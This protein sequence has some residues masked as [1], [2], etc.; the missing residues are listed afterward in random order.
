MVVSD[1]HDVPAPT[2]LIPKVL[3][4]QLVE[5]PSAELSPT[6][7]KRKRKTSDAAIIRLIAS[8]VEGYQWRLD[9]QVRDTCQK[10]LEA[11]EEQ[12]PAVHKRLK[13]FLRHSMPRPT[14]L[15]RAP[16]DIVSLEPTKLLLDQVVLSDEVEAEIR[17]LIT[18][19]QR[20]E[21][22]AEFALQPRH[23]VLLHGAPGNGK[24]ML[25]EALAGELGL[26]F[27]R[28]KYS[29]VVASHLGE[30]G[31]NIERLI[32]YASS[33]PCVLF[34]DEFDGLAIQRNQA[35]DVTEMRRVTN[36]MLISLDRLPAHC[37]FVAATNSP[38]L[39][40]PAILRRFDLPVEVPPPDE[41]LRRRAAELEL[42]PNLT[43]GMD[44]SH[45]AKDV[46]ALDL[47]NLY[48]VV[49]LCRRIRRDLVLNEGQGIKSLITGAVR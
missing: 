1:H 35:G 7:L 13:S 32:A 38:Q 11:T 30:T 40:D 4:N 25:A 24:T 42:N 17:S 5:S 15:L 45:L 49:N 27:L 18:E 9:D 46:G 31:K 3:M 6:E 34:L 26:P 22:L 28:V 20:S 37:I 36:Q 41:S 39:L 44:V 8:L 10:L 14:A 21:E 16:D 43:P 12:H 23:R 2:P 48:E 29:G 47:P 19:N 33:A